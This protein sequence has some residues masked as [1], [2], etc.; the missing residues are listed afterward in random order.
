M[1]LLQHSNHIKS[2]LTELALINSYPENAVSHFEGFNK[3]T[4][5]KIL[6][7]ILKQKAASTGSTLVTCSTY[8]NTSATDPTHQTVITCE[9]HGILK[10]QSTRNTHS[11][12]TLFKQQVHLLNLNIVVHLQ[13]VIVATEK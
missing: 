11:K 7:K 3:F 9:H 2:K 5:K 10:N 1:L 6:I 4:D 12:S 8:D 13:K